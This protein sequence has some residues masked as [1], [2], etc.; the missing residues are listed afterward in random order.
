MKAQFGAWM[1]DYGREYATEREYDERLAI[2]SENAKMV[3]EHNAG[4]HSYTS[5][6]ASINQLS[7]SLIT[8][9]FSSMTSSEVE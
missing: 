6:L 3:F 8:W 2:F 5:T 9:L 4:K 7:G 1:N